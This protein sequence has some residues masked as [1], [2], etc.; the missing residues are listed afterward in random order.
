MFVSRSD[1][2]IK[3]PGFR[4]GPEEVSD[5]LHASGEISETMVTSEPDPSAASESWLSWCRAKAGISIA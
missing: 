4:V 1:R 5:V 3:T 2:L